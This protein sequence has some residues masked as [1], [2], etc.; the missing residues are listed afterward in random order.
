MRVKQAMDSLRIPKKDF[1]ILEDGRTEEEV[2]VIFIKEGI[3]QGFVFCES[4]ETNQT[5]FTD[6]KKYINE[7]PD[8]SD[9]RRIIR[10]FLK[11]NKEARILDHIHFLG[12]RLVMRR[13]FVARTGRI[14]H[15][16][17]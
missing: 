5:E 9:S 17:L 6:L 8:N 11:N 10:A 7:Y 15:R 3:Y 16:L 1:L 2:G 4:K 13:V 12:S 14:A